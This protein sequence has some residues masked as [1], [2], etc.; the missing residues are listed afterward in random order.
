MKFVLEWLADVRAN[1]SEIKFTPR[2]VIDGSA[3][4]NIKQFL[5]EEKWQTNCVQLIINF[6]KVAIVIG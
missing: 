1:N 4:G 6:I 2:F 3:L 5:Y